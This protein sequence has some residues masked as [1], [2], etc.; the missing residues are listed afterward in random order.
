MDSIFLGLINDPSSK[1][2]S[3]VA[4]T[5]QNHLFEV[6]NSDGTTEAVDLLATNVNRGRDHGIPGYNFIRERCGLTK[7]SDFSGLADVMTRDNI[8]KLRAIYKLVKR[9][10]IIVNIK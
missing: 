7:A 1:F 3:N 2:D 10:H 5:L 6:K 4:D 8:E 9:K